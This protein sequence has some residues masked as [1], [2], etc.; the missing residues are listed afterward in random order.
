MQLACS[1]AGV[2][3]DGRGALGAVWESCRVTK[4]DEIL[5]GQPL[6]DRIE[7]SKTTDAGVEDADWPAPGVWCIHWRIVPEY[8]VQKFLYAVGALLALLVLFGLALPRASL[9]E[10]S[11]LIDAQP[12]TVF[13]LV[14]DFRR[15]SLWAPKTANDPNARVVFSGPARGVGATISWDG[16][17]VGSGTQT[18]T[19]SQPYNS[20]RTSINPGEAG[21]ALTWFEIAGE[22]NQTKITWGFRHDYGLNLVG[23]YFALLFSGVVRREY[24]IGISSLKELAESLPRTDFSDLDVEHLVVEADQ[25]A[26]RP[27]TSKP[28]PGSIS[29]AMGEAYFDVLAYIDE[30][31]LTESGAPISI[32]RSYVGANLRFDAAIPV[33]GVT[34]DTPA[35]DGKVKL[36]YTYGGPVIRVAHVGSYRMLGGTHRKIA[37]YLAALGLE[38][39]GDAWEAY[40]NDPT[41][42]A[43]SDLLTYVYYPVRDR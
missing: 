35:E 16:M 10:V 18:I 6:A 5:P 33:T 38:R 36:G 15:I 12:A 14:N 27:T 42:V 31:G 2:T 21:E 13:A 23:R 22:G 1:L 7:H 39:S 34:D 43:E 29:N 17:I 11:A 3:I 24:E 20:V 8:G 9:V 25:I 26:Y 32:A 4:V 28:E 30:N 37:S 40:V 41:R 19:A